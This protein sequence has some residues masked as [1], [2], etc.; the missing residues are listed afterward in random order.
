MFKD[1]SGFTWWG[2]FIGFAFCLGGER[3]YDSFGL[4]PTL[5]YYAVG[6]ALV[7]FYVD[8]YMGKFKVSKNECK[9]GCHR[10]NK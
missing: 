5:L 6:M 2:L 10:G 4:W 3:V 8:R 1:G 9:C 7:C